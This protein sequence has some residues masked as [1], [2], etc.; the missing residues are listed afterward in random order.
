VKASSPALFS[1]STPVEVLVF[2]PELDELRRTSAEV[3]GRLEGVEGLRDVRSS[4]VAGFP[5]VRLRYDRALM[6][7][8]GLS[9]SSV[10]AALRDKIQGVEAT[11]M[12]RGEKRV[13]M[14]VRLVEADRASLADLERVNV[15]PN[16]DPPIPLSAVATLESAEGPSE[17]RRVDQRRAAVITANLEGFDLNAAREGIAQ[18][19]VGLDLEPGYSYT[20]AGQAE[21]MD[22]SLD[23]MIF[24]L[25]LAVFLVYVIMASTFESLV[26]PF[27]ILFTVPMAAVGVLPVL[28]ITGTPLSVVAFIGVIVLAGVVVNNAIVLVDRIN[29]G[30]EQG[31][32]LEEAVVASG[33][34]RLRPIFITTATTVI[35]L[36]PLSLGFGA[37]A[38]LQQPLAV[39][40]IAGLSAS[41]LLTLLVIPAIYLLIERLRL[42][43]PRRPRRRRAP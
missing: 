22:R 43:G 20:L 13:D 23:A 34:A 1:F 35:G 28:L 42:P 25:L 31:E 39:T 12:S 27:I 21:E 36:L 19:L 41:T 9:T 30:R 8:F 6:D 29:R 15:N 7:R 3:V 17:V 26:H 38:E 10:A 14:V 37:G 18:A 24:A 33:R 40:V 2:G 32:S 5:E 11:R 16:L 4:L